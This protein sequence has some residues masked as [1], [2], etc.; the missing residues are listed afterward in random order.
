VVDLYPL[1]RDERAAT[2]VVPPIGTVAGLEVTQRVFA[3]QVV[4]RGGRGHRPDRLAQMVVERVGVDRRSDATAAQWLEEVLGIDPMQCPS[5]GGRLQN[6]E[7]PR[8][9]MRD[10]LRCWQ[11]QPA[12]PADRVRSRA[13]PRAATA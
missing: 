12:K 10:P 9:P 4:Q 8:G 13:P 6:D 5:C 11:R 3:G 2:Q 7:L 1:G